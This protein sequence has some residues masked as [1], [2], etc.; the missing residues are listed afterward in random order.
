MYTR[1]LF[2]RTS[3]AISSITSA[4]CLSLRRRRADRQRVNA[5]HERV[6]S[7][8]DQLVL[9]D[10]RLSVERGRRH[11]DLEVI[12]R[13]GRVLDVHARSGKRTLDR[14]P[15]LLGTRHPPSSGRYTLPL[16]HASGG[17]E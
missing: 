10:G 5:R 6:E 13:T 9:L 1:T 15:D 17:A 7:A 4:I 14:E 11:L 12:A 8:V 16:D 2:S 3:R